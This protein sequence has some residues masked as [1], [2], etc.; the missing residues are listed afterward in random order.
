MSQTIHTSLGTSD[1]QSWAISN[2]VASAF[3]TFFATEKE[4]L[5]AFETIRVLL[6]DIVQTLNMATF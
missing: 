1:V 4:M 3:Q 5:E 2:F 6:W